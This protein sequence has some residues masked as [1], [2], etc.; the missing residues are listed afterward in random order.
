MAAEMDPVNESKLRLVKS[1]HTVIWVILASTVLFIVWSGITANTSA[2]SWLA[3]AAVLVE[4][5]V[6]MIYGGSC[7][8]TKVARRYSG[9]TSD[10]FD[11]YLPNWL[12]RYNKLIFGTLFILGLAMMLM[13][14]FRAG[15]RY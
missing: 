11:I 9:S 4:G 15:F 13:N 3:V 6:L 8:L 1:I 2:Y 10:N 12:A 7:P 14:S 5:I